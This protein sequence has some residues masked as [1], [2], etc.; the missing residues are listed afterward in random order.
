MGFIAALK[1]ELAGKV[2]CIRMRGD[3]GHKVHHDVM[4]CEENYPLTGN[5]VNCV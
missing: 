3:K 4:F 5:L 2:A 1:A